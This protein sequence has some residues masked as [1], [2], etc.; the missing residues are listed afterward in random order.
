[1]SL[2]GYCKL[3]TSLILLN[4]GSAGLSLLILSKIASA[5]ASLLTIILTLAPSPN[6]SVNP[7]YHLKVLT[8]AL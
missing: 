4:P 5:S 8:D 1:M 6:F 7:L 2:L 3:V